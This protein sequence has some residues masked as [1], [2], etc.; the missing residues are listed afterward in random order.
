MKKIVFLIFLISA[1]FLSAVNRKVKCIKRKRKNIF[2]YFNHN[3]FVN[4]PIISLDIN[5]LKLRKIRIKKSFLKARPLFNVKKNILI[6]TS[7]GGGGHIAVANALK[8]YLSN[9]YNIKIA[10]FFEDVMTSLDIVR[11]FTFGQLSSEDFYNL[12]LRYNFIKLL[13]IFS[14][15]GA[16]GLRTRQHS[17]E[18]VLYDYI[19]K[20]DIKPDLIVSVIP[21]VNNVI[22]SAAEKLDIPFLI[23]TNDLDT[24]N[25]IN[26]ITKVNYKKFY[27]T[28][29]FDDRDILEKIEAANIPSNQIVFSGFPL[30]PEFFY[31]NKDKEPIYKDFDIPEDK[32]KVMV[33]MGGAGSYACYK[34]VKSLSRYK[35]PIHIIAC[36]GREE[37]LRAS[38]NKIKLPP[39]ITLS[40]IGYTNRISDLMAIS[41]VLITKSGPG[42]ICEAIASNLPMIIDKTNDIIRWENMNVDFVKKYKLGEV[43]TNM[44][45]L[46]STLDKLLSNFDYRQEISHNINSFN[47]KLSFQD[48]ITNLVKGILV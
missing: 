5:Q 9:F 42:S 41:D 46:H 28:L 13:N 10:N 22:L 14:R 26:G 21:M 2:T 33:L 39:H 29:S 37:S 47:G 44:R 45:N 40:I 38:I 25:Y 3:K 43:L 19:N 11:T 23:I 36:I 20:L 16:W 31:K 12:C 35:Y 8:G 6:F 24:V 15:V 17:M 1:N 4:T 30:R 48:K 18:K 7:K 27:Y 34:Y 32:K